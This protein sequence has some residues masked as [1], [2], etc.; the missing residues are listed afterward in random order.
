MASTWIGGELVAAAMSATLAAVA[1]GSSTANIGTDGTD[2][3]H[4][5]DGGGAQ[6]QDSG[7][8]SLP[9]D[10]RRDGPSFGTGDGALSDAPQAPTEIYVIGWE[11]EGQNMG[12]SPESLYTYD[13]RTNTLS[14]VGVLT[15]DCS[16]Q[17]FQ[18][19]IQTLAIDCAGNA[20]GVGPSGDGGAS[21]SS[22]STLCKVDLATAVT[23][24]IAESPSGDFR[25]LCPSFQREGAIPT[26]TRLWVT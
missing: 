26:R 17:P 23:T 4:G 13:P 1:C 11:W 2:G 7:G 3:T 5:P 20:Y 25:P 6:N 22:V 19:S 10:A 21:L 16:F 8:I 15:G 24:R 18:I 14:L 12:Y 9:G